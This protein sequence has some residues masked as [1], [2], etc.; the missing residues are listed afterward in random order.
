MSQC[1]EIKDN[2]RTTM[3]ETQLKRV[4][5]KTL[6]FFCPVC[7]TRKMIALIKN[8]YTCLSC[9]ALFIYKLLGFYVKLKVK[10]P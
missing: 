2:N 1:T 7:G 6:P 3:T 10:A 9:D 5:C 8:D 4:G